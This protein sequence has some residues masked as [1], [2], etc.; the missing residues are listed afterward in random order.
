MSE[1]P[2]VIRADIEATRARLGTNVDAV[3]DKVTPSNIVHRQTDKVR[4]AVTGVKEK[5]MG[6]ADTHT[7]NA[8][9]TT[10]DTLNQATETVS[11]KLTDAGHAVSNTPDQ[12]KAKTAGNPLAAGL[13]AFGAGMLLSSLIPASDKEREAADH[14]KTAAQPLAEHVTETAKTMAQDLKEP[15][16][17]AMD[18]V[19]A[20]ATDAAQNLKTESQ[21]AATDVKDRATDAK[22]TIHN[23]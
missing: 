22:D 18:N 11:A 17:E 23:S 9:H 13:I 15:A 16:Q 20:T 5:I 12:V 2:D 10:G 21:T 1:N 6:A 8:M 3:A 4:D 7:S 19:K 14:L